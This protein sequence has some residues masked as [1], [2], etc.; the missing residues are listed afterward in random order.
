MPVSFDIIEDGRICVLT[1][2]NPWTIAE[3]TQFYP[4]LKNHLDTAPTKV[5]LL[6]DFSQVSLWKGNAFQARNAPFTGHPNMGF[7][8][9][10]STS[11]FVNAVAEAMIKVRHTDYTRFFQSTTEGLDFLRSEI[12]TG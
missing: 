5:H 6:F 11:T 9:M 12:S 2:T 8:A 10:I 3:F 1:A 4:Q 7:L